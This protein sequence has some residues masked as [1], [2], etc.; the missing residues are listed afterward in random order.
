VST[1]T[2]TEELQVSGLSSLSDSLGCG[3]DGIRGRLRWVTIGSRDVAA[4]GTAASARRPRGRRVKCGS[5]R[6]SGEELVLILGGTP[7]ISA[8]GRSRK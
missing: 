7:G 3:R 8:V 5:T 6:W 1:A 2:T 4:S